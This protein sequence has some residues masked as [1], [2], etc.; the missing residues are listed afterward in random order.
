MA[1]FA[2]IETLPVNGPV[3]VNLATVEPE[4][5]EWLW[6]DRVAVGK[7]TLLTGDPGLGKSFITLDMAA[8]VSKGL[9][10]PDHT[11]AAAVQGGV[12]LLSAED[13]PADTIRPRLDALGADPAQLNL[14]SAVQSDGG[15]TGDWPDDVAASEA[16]VDLTKHICELEQAIHQTPNCRLVIIDPIAAYLGHT[17]SHR[18]AAL[19]GVLS[20][21]ARIAANNRVAVVAVAHLN[22]SAGGK[23]VYRSSG[24]IAFVAAARSAW[25]VTKDRDDPKRRLVLPLKNNLAPDVHGLAYSIEEDAI[26]RQPSVL[27]E[28]DP[29]MI[30]AEEALGDPVGDREES[31]EVQDWLRSTLAGTDGIPAK[32]MLEQAEANGFSHKAA[33]K[34][35]KAAG[36]KAVRAG[37]GKD[38]AWMWRLSQSSLNPIGAFVT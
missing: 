26:T 1:S 5:V 27:W 34:A 36:G 20:P 16:H 10:W 8:R 24:S 15:D 25:A 38:G 30:S 37:F 2:P 7:L 6:P 12:V 17:D 18:D 4:Q 29:V 9:P 13:D 22:K 31:D 11:D 21:L 3:L 14:L 33:R 19:R 28:P 35:L 23:A 32:E